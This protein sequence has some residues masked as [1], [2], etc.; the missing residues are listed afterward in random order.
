MHTCVIE[1]NPVS[2][3]D[4]TLDATN[5]DGTRDALMFC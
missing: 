2:G 1:M 5:D 3:A 4:A